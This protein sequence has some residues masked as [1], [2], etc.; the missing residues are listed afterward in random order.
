MSLILI[1]ICQPCWREAPATAPDALDP[2]GFVASCADKSVC[3][4]MWMFVWWRST[5]IDK[6]LD[7]GRYR[8]NYINK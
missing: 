1:K 6:W 2:Y 8:H 4:L 7:R 5:G 3:S